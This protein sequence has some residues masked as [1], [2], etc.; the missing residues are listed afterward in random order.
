MTGLWDRFRFLVLAALGS[1]LLVALGYLLGREGRPPPALELTPPAGELRVYVIGAV[2][3]PGVYTLHDGARWIDALEAA[4]G[5]A[6]DADL[7]R[8]NLARRARDEDHIVVPRVGE[9]PVATGARLIDIN[10]ASARELE[11][12]PGVGPVRAERIVQSR[13]SDGPFASPE[14]LLTRRLVP[15]SV[16]DQIK[17]LVTVGP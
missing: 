9:T 3:H 2:Q 11:A 16:Y 4:G 15:Q 13:E 8:I 1:P 12:L 17:D 7:A 10:S 5:P 6:A 14:E